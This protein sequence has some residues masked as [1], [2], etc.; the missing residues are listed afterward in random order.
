MAL[1]TAETVLFVLF[2][3]LVNAF[4]VAL[5]VTALTVGALAALLVRRIEVRVEAD[6]E[7]VLLIRASDVCALSF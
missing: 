4:G 1:L 5:V 2:R 6:V 7:Q 3:T